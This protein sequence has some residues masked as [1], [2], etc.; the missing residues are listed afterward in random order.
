M[1]LVVGA[2]ARSVQRPSRNSWRRAKRCAL[3]RTP[4]AAEAVS[5]AKS[6]AEVVQGDLRAAAFMEIWAAMVGEPILKTGKT[7]IFGRGN[8]PINFVSAEDV[9]KFCVIALQ[10]PQ[11]RNQVIEIGG[12]E[13]LTFNQV[14]ELFGKASGRPA[15]KNHVPSLWSHAPR[16][17]GVDVHGRWRLLRLVIACLARRSK[18]LVV[19]DSLVQR[20]LPSTVP[21][22]RFHTGRVGQG[23]KTRRL[24]RSQG[25]HQGF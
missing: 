21:L 4:A 6:G 22:D 11:A 7:T 13:N 23:Q 24:N 20:G 9:A 25:F 1:I 2:P 10:D 17:L 12:P 14:A 5:L 3:T 19:K 18:H 15:K 8:N 16:S